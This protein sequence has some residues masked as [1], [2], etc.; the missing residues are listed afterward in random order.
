VVEDKDDVSGST[1]CVWKPNKS[2]PADERMV[3][4]IKLTT[5]AIGNEDIVG[6]THRLAINALYDDLGG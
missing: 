1:S 6:N 4:G 5:L 3:E 2:A